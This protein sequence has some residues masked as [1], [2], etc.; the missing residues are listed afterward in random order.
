MRQ[1]KEV[2]GQIDLLETLG[3]LLSGAEYLLESRESHD[4]S[5][6]PEL[7]RKQKHNIDISHRSIARIRSRI[8]REAAKLQTMTMSATETEKYLTYLI[9]R[10]DD[11]LVYIAGVE[12][13]YE[14][15]SIASV[16]VFRNPSDAQQYAHDKMQTSGGTAI[17]VLKRIR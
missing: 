5:L 6:F 7:A 4:F 10:S 13:D 9:V 3:S 16:E 12:E 17:T 2:R 8:A 11:D 1:V 15:A 14:G